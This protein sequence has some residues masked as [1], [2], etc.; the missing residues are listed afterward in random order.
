MYIALVIMNWK[1]DSKN[2]IK[3]MSIHDVTSYIIAHVQIINL[4]N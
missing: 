1:Y 4:F 2:S 3:L